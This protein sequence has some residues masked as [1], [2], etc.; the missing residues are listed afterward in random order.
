MAMLFTSGAEIASFNGMWSPIKLCGS[1]DVLVWFLF[2]FAVRGITLLLG[3]ISGLDVSPDGSVVVG[4]SDDVV[5]AHDT[6][7]GAALWRKKMAGFVPTLRIHEGWV[8]VPSC[9]SKTVVLD[10]TT[11][12]LLHTLPSAGDHVSG[13]CVFDGL[14]NHDILSVVVVL[15]PC[16][17]HSVASKN[18]L[19]GR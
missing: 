14:S 13:I 15:K 17:F 5:I 8:V 19:E 3:R 16:F 4:S 12:N 9:N 1:R 2:Q 11:G 10:I 6:A 18:S 7:T